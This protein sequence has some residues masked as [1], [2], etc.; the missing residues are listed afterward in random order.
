MTLKQPVDSSLGSVLSAI[1]ECYS[2]I[3]R[4][5]I[6]VQEDGMWDVKGRFPRV[7]TSQAPIN[8]ENENGAPQIAILA[9]DEDRSLINATGPTAPAAS[10]SVRPEAAAT[11]SSL[12]SLG[13]DIVRLL[14]IPLHLLVR[15]D[16]GLRLAYQKYLAVQSAKKRIDQ[17]MAA[18]EW[19]FE[20]PAF[21]DIVEVFV[22][23]SVWFQHY[24]TNFSKLSGYPIMMKWME[25]GDEAPRDWDVWGFARQSY[26]FKD[27][28]HY[29]SK[30]EEVH[31]P[32]LDAPVLKRKDRS[33]SDAAA[34]SQAGP[35]KKK[36]KS[37][38]KKSVD[39]SGQKKGGQKK[40]G[41]SKGTRK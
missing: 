16:I 18:G 41:K 36:G 37:S 12:N 13:K 40:G 38:D 21:I 17:M 7:V 14:N 29:L 35:S 39:E 2:P 24:H 1:E 30:P 19:R 31:S 5:R 32:I 23:K 25:G 34:A 3:A 10:A 20:K 33:E 8:W 9:V 11:L 27:L 26:S 4:R 15:K 6:L 22:S 28:K